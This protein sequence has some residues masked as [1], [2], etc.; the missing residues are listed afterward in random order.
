MRLHGWPAKRLPN[1][2]PSCRRVVGAKGIPANRWRVPRKGYRA[3][4]AWCKTHA[5]KSETAPYLPRGP[6]EFEDLNGAE[7]A[8]AGPPPHRFDPFGAIMVSRTGRNLSFGCPFGS[9]WR[10]PCLHFGGWRVKWTWAHSC[11]LRRVRYWLPH[12]TARQC[13]SRG[14]SAGWRTPKASGWWPILAAPMPD[15]I[16]GR[17][18]GSNEVHAG[19]LRTINSRTLPH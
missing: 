9:R 5:A 2:D 13:R 1:A 7:Q 15:S 17:A 19:R 6:K 18:A 4:R 12:Q 14:W 11:Q 10:I 3:I 16:A 8:S